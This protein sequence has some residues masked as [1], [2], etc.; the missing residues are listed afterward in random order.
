M[1]SSD[2]LIIIKS[3]IIKSIIIKNTNQ[4]YSIDNGGTL[5]LP[6]YFRQKLWTDEQRIQLAS[7]ALDENCIYIEGKR[8][9]REIGDVAIAKMYRELREKNQRLGFT[10]YT[11]ANQKIY[12]RIRRRAIHK[13]RFEEE[14]AILRK[15]HTSAEELVKNK[16]DWTIL[17]Q[18]D[19]ID[20]GKT[21]K[22]WLPK[23]YTMS[24]NWT[25]DWVWDGQ[26]KMNE[27]DN[28]Y[29]Q[30]PVTKDYTKLA[31]R[32]QLQSKK[33][34]KIVQYY[35]ANIGKSLFT[36]RAENPSEARIKIGKLTKWKWETVKW[37]T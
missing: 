3:I 6:Q 32:M 16:L 10:K 2:L 12:E 20:N 1:C 7:W 25:P 15:N 17:R 30:C 26:H 9:S 37:I 18:K 5:P 4:R 24:E 27:I 34:D 21:T 14:E 13:K 33:Q 23:E 29:E 35:R 11:S 8:I 36:V 31:Q 22:D 19:Y 28:F